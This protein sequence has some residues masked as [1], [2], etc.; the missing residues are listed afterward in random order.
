MKINKI[1]TQH[2]RDFTAEYQCEYCGYIYEGSGYDD[3]YF[4]NNVVPSMK[5]QMCGKEAGDGYEPLSTKYPDEQV[6]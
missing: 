3:S 2:R 6:V 1:L 5:C 4:H